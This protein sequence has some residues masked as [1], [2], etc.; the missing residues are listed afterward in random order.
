MC[1]SCAAVET[2][3]RETDVGEIAD[4]VVGA[5]IDRTVQIRIR[6]AVLPEMMVLTGIYDIAAVVKNPAAA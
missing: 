5:G 6:E 4:Q 3:R 1:L 2:Q